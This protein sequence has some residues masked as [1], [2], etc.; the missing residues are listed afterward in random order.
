M[1]RWG[2]RGLAAAA[3]FALVVGIWL[4]LAGGPSAIA[5]ELPVRVE[6]RDVSLTVFNEFETDRATLY[7]PVAG[8]LYSPVAGDPFLYAI[9]QSDGLTPVVREGMAL[10]K[11]RRIVLNLKKGDNEVRFTDVAATIDPTSV[12]LVS[13]TDPLGTKVV[14]QNFEY[15][16]ATADA[17]LKR[18][19][20]RRITCVVKKDGAEIGGYLAS[21][22][23][24][25]IVLTEKPTTGGK[26]VL[27]K[28]QTISRDNLRAIR[29]PDVPED[30]H[31]RPTLVWKLRTQRPGRHETTLNY[32]CGQMKWRADYVAIVE[33]GPADGGD[34][35]DL[36][37]WVTI[38]NQS[39]STYEEAGIKLIAGDVN[40]V[41]DPWA[42]P[43][44]SDVQVF[45]GAEVFREGPMGGFRDQKKFIEK[46]FFEYHL[47]TLSAPSTVRD[48]QIKQ[49][50]LL[51][52]HDV[53]A[54]RRHVFESGAHF[55]DDG[56]PQLAVELVFKNEKANRLGIPLP[57]G[58]VRMLQCDAEGELELVGRH[59][60][61]HTP[62]DEE[63]VWQLGRAFNVLGE[64]TFVDAEGFI[65]DRAMEMDDPR[66]NWEVSV[67]RLRVRNHA[68]RSINVR[69]LEVI[70]VYE[71]DAEFEKID[72]EIIKATH[73][74]TKHD[75][76]RIQFDFVLG[77]DRE[78]VI[79]YAV[80]HQWPMEE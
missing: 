20:D 29:L 14:E 75:S 65:E 5:R 6:R 62:V 11:D 61:D 23:A 54:E 44:D 18:Y 26:T 9:V 13:D 27:P 24:S 21:Y 17:I 58:S 57:K 39:G 16:L 73:P 4:L 48:R 38:E 53:R 52:A 34:R 31:T 63:L 35:L 71:E 30:L 7:S 72:W 10:V 69:C 70:D 1:R 8:M 76:R 41:P 12:R 46:A 55:G 15:D 22:D 77:P 37:G 42:P 43:V 74:W 66:I 59:K 40:R 33:P 67:L 78:Q 19:I 50:N 68:A 64:R 32:L 79:T 80:E 28:I 2:L 51:E 49:L 47:Y 36:K 60:L 3:G 25:S 45:N 56:S